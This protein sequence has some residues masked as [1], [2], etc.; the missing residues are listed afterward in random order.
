M[1]GE[2]L[3]ITVASAR[4]RPAGDGARQ[5]LATYETTL[6]PA[7]DAESSTGS[8]VARLTSRPAARL[9]CLAP[10]PAARQ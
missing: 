3:W 2:W 4:S 10:P 8:S 7:H 1:L 6:V 9:I 5:F